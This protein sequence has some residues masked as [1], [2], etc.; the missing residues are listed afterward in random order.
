M[1]T[2]NVTTDWKLP[3]SAHCS[4]QTQRSLDTNTLI[5]TSN[6]RSNKI[7]G[8]DMSRVRALVA[9]FALICG[10]VIFL[11]AQTQTPQAP[12]PQ[13]PNIPDK[14]TNLQVLPKTISKPELVGIMKQFCITFKVRCSYCHVATDDLSEANFAADDKPTKAEARK[15]LHSIL[16]VKDQS[17]E[18][19]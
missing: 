5:H 14:Y 7:Q 9:V 17:A 13:R 8:D 6:I 3:K 4:S 18:V 2:S 19:K 12:P 10:C 1:E 16:A 15:L 11:V